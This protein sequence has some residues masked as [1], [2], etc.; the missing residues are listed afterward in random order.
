MLVQFKKEYVPA[1][2]IWHVCVGA[3]VVGVDA[4]EE[5]VVAT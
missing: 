4:A 5:E 3:D 1:E 2:A